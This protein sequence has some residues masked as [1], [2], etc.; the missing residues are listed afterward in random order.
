MAEGMFLVHLLDSENRLKN[1][2][3]FY[4][5]VLSAF[6]FIPPSKRLKGTRNL[7]RKNLPTTKCKSE[8]AP[9][10]RLDKFIASSHR[11]FAVEFFCHIRPTHRMF[12]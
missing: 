12:V 9:D 10:L 3:V 6:S 4:A 2:C 1:Q 8:K 11:I 5:Q 7:T